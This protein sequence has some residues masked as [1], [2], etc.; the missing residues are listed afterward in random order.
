MVNRSPG[1]VMPVL[2]VTEVI[3]HRKKKQQT[4]AGNRRRTAETLG[5]RWSKI[6]TGTAYTQILKNFREQKAD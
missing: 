2:T 5:C 6:R 4:L 3:Q 1:I